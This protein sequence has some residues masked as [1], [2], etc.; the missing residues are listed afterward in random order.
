MK[1]LVAGSS[2]TR[3]DVARLR[4]FVRSFARFVFTPHP[5]LDL[6][7]NTTTSLTFSFHPSSRARRALDLS[8]AVASASPVV[9]KAL[10][11]YPIAE[12]RRRRVAAASHRAPPLDAHAPAHPH[13]RRTSRN[14][15][16]APERTLVPARRTSRA[17]HEANKSSRTRFHRGADRKIS[18]S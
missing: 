6:I 4:S 11:G 13:G 15:I 12:P 14:K 18:R 16:L 10:I 3:R 7:L 17:T 9:S 8:F 5:R 2:S 1:S